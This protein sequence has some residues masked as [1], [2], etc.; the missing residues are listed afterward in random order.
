MKENGLNL[1]ELYIER[2]EESD[3]TSGVM[4]DLEFLIKSVTVIG[5]GFWG[6]LMSELSNIMR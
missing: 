5:R 3:M 2:R 4:T 1:T 6:L